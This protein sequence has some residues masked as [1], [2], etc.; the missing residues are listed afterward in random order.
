M[1]RYE[2]ELEFRPEETRASVE[3][4]LAHLEGARSGWSTADLGP[5]F[6]G[7]LERIVA[8]RALVRS[9][10]PS[11]KLEQD[12]SGAIFEQITSRI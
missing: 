1:L 2:V 7:L 5:R 3:R 6:E 4:L 10:S 11:F 9:T 8:F 12:E